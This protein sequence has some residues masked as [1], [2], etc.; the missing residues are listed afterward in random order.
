[1]LECLACM[2]CPLPWQRLFIRHDRLAKRCRPET[3]VIDLF[4]C[5]CW[6]KRTVLKTSSS[7]G[8]YGNAVWVVIHGLDRPV[9][10]FKRVT[11]F[12][13]VTMFN[14]EKWIRD[15]LEDNKRLST[16][17]NAA[18]IQ[19]ETSR[20]Q[21]CDLGLACKSLAPH[22]GTFVSETKT[23][24]ARE[25]RRVPLRRRSANCDTFR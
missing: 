5:A 25:N 15:A 8:K 22:R 9:T 6:P 20:N 12:K 24:R 19:F 23:R 1:M 18:A 14:I 7:V 17:V 13:R 11:I 16:K 10:M 2:S 21:A 4:V 3:I